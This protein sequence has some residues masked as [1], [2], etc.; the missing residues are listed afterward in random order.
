MW[1]TV[2]RKSL[3]EAFLAGLKR[4][5]IDASAFSD[6]SS[7][8][9]EMRDRSVNRK[10]SSTTN[11]SA[12]SNQSSQYTQ[13]MEALST[14]RACGSTAASASLDTPLEKSPATSTRDALLPSGKHLSIE[15]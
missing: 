11:A 2:E 5:S 1:L 7:Y 15:G 3:K 9:Q 14:N 13:E 12:N 10:R 4:D 6:Q 8:T